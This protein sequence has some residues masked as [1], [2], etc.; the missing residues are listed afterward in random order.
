MLHIHPLLVLHIHLLL[1]LSAQR[2]TPFLG[3]QASL[4]TYEVQLGPLAYLFWMEVGIMC[5]LL[6][7]AL[8]T[9]DLQTVLQTLLQTY[10]AEGQPVQGWSLQE[11][12]LVWLSAAL[13]GVR[14]RGRRARGDNGSG[15]LARRRWRRTRFGFIH[16]GSSAPN[17]ETIFL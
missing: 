4:D 17:A 8:L 16:G 9:G 1:V 13:G 10:S 3:A 7:W 6:P 2:A 11:W 14:D 5:L 15:V 12:G